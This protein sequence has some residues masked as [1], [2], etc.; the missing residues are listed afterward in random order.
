M[1]RDTEITPESNQELK[2]LVLELQAKLDQQTQFIDQLLEQIRLARY[3]HFGTRSERY[4]LDQLALVFNEAEAAAGQTPEDRS[5]DDT[6][7][8]S[9][10][11]SIVVP[12]YLRKRGGRKPLPP[13]LPRV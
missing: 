9:A 5:T 3:Q 10:A 11:D 4:S 1:N 2:A 7:A 6:D 13:E 12:A 8:S